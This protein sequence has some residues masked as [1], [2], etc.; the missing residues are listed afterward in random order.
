[1]PYSKFKLPELKKKFNLRIEKNT[2]FSD[3]KV[4]EPSSWLLE[5][6]QIGKHLSLLTEKVR[7]ETIVMP[8]LMELVKQN[9]YSI[10]LFSGISF[11][12]NE[13]EGLNGECDFI[14]GLD[15]NAYMLESPVI[16]LIEAKDNDINEGLAQCIAQMIGAME[17][18]KAEGKEIDCIFG[19][20]TTGTDWQF[21]K[22]Y[23]NIVTYH[24]DLLYISDL[25]FL[26]G[27]WQHIIQY[28]KT[29]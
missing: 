26:L 6:L 18:N 29:I 17:F 4:L 2:L 1:M 9:N 21:L 7:S 13:N 25:P 3:V 10:S 24:T 11:D 20:I 5:S 22:L 23:G 28:Y 15:G 14:I 8:V 12:V 19:C 16:A 27:F